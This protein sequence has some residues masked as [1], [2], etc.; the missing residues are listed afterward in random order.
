[1]RELIRPPL[2]NGEISLLV[3][4][5]PSVAVKRYRTLRSGPS[6]CGPQPRNES[7]F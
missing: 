4:L 5:M 1:M 7:G 3:W 6:P 2:A